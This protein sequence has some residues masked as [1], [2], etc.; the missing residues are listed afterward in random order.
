[1]GQYYRD[2][3][4]RYL[5]FGLWLTSAP[6]LAL[7]FYWTL[8]LVWKDGEDLGSFLRRKFVARILETVH[9]PK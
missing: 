8:D 2:A 4:G 1:M 3:Y 5:V 7:L 6:F 9:G